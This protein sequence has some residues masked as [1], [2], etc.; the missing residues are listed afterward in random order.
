[1]LW[2]FLFP[3]LKHKAS[4]ELLVVAV[5]DYGTPGTCSACLVLPSSRETPQGARLALPPGT[6]QRDGKL[7]VQNYCSDLK[8]FSQC[9]VT[10]WKSHTFFFTANFGNAG[11]RGSPVYK[12]EHNVSLQALAGGKMPR[13]P[14]SCIFNPK[15]Q[16]VKGTPSLPCLQ[17]VCSQQ[18]SA[19]SL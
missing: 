10:G 12:G 6:E 19:C 14:F 5:F 8:F 4:H 2:P 3:S 17:Q 9:G 16:P 7:Q 13:E 1:M 15:E 11:K 18:R